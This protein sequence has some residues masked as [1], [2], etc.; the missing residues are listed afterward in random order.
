MVRFTKFCADQPD[1]PGGS[2][3]AY[4]VTPAAVHRFLHLYMRHHVCQGGDCKGMEGHDKQA[5][6]TCL[7]A[8][9]KLKV[10]VLYSSTRR[11]PLPG[12]AWCL[13]AHS[14]L[15]GV[16]EGVPP[17]VVRG[18]QAQGGSGCAGGPPRSSL[19]R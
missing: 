17:G 15:A 14:L 18:G 19:K 10:S 12:N 6:N 1:Q 3:H 11:S 7:S 4:P 9:N 2:H 5:L 16:A 13:L 8:L